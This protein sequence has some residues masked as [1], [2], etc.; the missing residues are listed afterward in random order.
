MRS[1]IFSINLNIFDLN[2]HSIYKIIYV[3]CIL[4]GKFFLER[5]KVDA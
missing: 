5:E 1:F 3:D 4:S 2:G